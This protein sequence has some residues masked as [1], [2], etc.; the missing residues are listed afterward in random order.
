[1]PTKHKRISVTKD[2][3]L[4]EALHRARFL[5]PGEPDSAVVR[6]MA[7]RGIE[8][9]LADEERSKMLRE[10]FIARIT[11]PD[12]PYMTNDE[13]EEIERDGLDLPPATP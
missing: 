2:P 11:G 6:A 10:R 12:W 13:I 3:E 8:G 9:M 4:T 5:M 1:M 7:I